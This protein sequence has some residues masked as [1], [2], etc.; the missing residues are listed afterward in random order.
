M[1]TRAYL[2]LGSN[3]G[4]REENLRSALAR[5]G[6]VGRIV[7]AS[8]LYETEPVDF[9]AQ[10]WF[11]NAVVAMET[12][13]TPR[14]LLNAL[15]ALEQSMGRKRDL[16]KGPRIVDLDILLYGDH[17]IHEAGLTIPHP[18][19]PE[20]RFVL[21]PLVEIAPDV[22]H[23]LLNKSMCELRDALPPGQDVRKLENLALTDSL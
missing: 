15:L 20:R 2:S 17:T 16:P 14:E 23:P 10:P 21:E 5:L 19:L 18:G 13:K 1:P 9:A 8:H 4:N 11:L 3:I 7:E 12:E 22:L 6:D